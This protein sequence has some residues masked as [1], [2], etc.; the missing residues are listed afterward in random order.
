M[1]ELSKTFA[2]RFPILYTNRPPSLP[3][4]LAL[5]ER[6]NEEDGTPLLGVSIGREGC[7]SKRENAPTG[8]L[9]KLANA[10]VIRLFVRDPDK[11]A[12][13][14][15]PLPTKT[16]VTRQT[17]NFTYQIHLRA[18]KNSIPLCKHHATSC[19]VYAVVAGQ[20]A[21]YGFDCVAR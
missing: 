4:L 6:L 5:T 1:L 20:C 15:P 13:A 11:H 19:V 7:I 9:L 14:A 17:S 12:V 21:M 3:T 8:S 2:T 10:F 18:R 16:A